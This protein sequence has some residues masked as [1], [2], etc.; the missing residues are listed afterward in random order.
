MR[1]GR[2]SSAAFE[3]K[4]TRT[5]SREQYLSVNS[6]EVDSLPVVVSYYKEVLQDNLGQ[7][8]LTIHKIKECNLAGQVASVSV[9]FDKNQ[10]S[11]VFEKL[12]NKLP[13]YRLRRTPISD[14]HSGIEFV[15]VFGDNALA[16]KKFSRKMANKKQLNV[17]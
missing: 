6:L 7:V 9:K 17:Y 2:A 3:R 16:E 11:W 5:E 13:A 14:S 10:G 4:T 8:A 15:N 12:G 1:G